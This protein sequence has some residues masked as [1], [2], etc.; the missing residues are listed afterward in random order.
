VVTGKH[1]DLDP[2]L[3]RGTLDRTRVTTVRELGQRREWRGRD[4][5]RPAEIAGNGDVIPAAVIGV[6]VLIPVGRDD[7]DRSLAPFDAGTPWR[8]MKPP[9]RSARYRSGVPLPRV[10]WPGAWQGIQAHFARA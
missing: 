10:S 4:E 3:A 7:L 5:S 8:P 9:R 1:F 2:G 6:Q